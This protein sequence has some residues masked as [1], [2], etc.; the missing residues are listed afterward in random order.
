M[1]LQFSRPKK[2]AQSVNV[3]PIYGGPKLRPPGRSRPFEK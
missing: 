1:N 3:P 2:F